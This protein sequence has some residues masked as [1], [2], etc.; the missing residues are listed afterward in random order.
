MADFCETCVHRD[1]RGYC[2]CEKLDEDTG[3]LP[4]QAI[5]MLLYSFTEGGGFLVGPKFGCIHH[6]LKKLD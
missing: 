3:Y 1:L 2:H 6:K 5:D 4:E